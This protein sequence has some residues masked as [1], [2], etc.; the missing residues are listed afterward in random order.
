MNLTGGVYVTTGKY[1]QKFAEDWDQPQDY[2]ENFM[3]CSAE[4]E[5]L[6]FLV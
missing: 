2:T 1:L 4:H 5:I 3:L 6:T